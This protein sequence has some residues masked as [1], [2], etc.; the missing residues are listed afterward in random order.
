MLPEFQLNVSFFRTLHQIDLELARSCQQAGCPY[1]NA[2]LHNASYVRKPRGCPIDLPEEFSIRL[3][4]C[5]SRENCRRR[6]LPPSC[7]FMGRKVYWG[8]VILI[9]M[10]L[11]QRKTEG[12]A[13]NMLA[14]KFDIPGKTVVRWIHYFRDEFCNSTLWKQLRGQL[15]PLLRNSDIPGAPVEYFTVHHSS[16]KDGLIACLRFLSTG[17]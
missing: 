15:T 4:L 8:A 12:I 14:R 1:C 17:T 3:S 5:C 16:I 9:I 11:R 7:L 6:T 2:P 13:I 10:T